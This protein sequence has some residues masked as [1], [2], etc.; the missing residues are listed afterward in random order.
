MNEPATLAITGASGFLGRSLLRVAA[1]H[2]FRVRALS[3]QHRTDLPGVE[4]FQGDISDDLVLKDLA[5]GCSSLIHAAATMQGA[6][7][8]VCRSIVDGTA[9]AAH[10]ASEAG[11]R[12]VHISSLA[13]VNPELAADPVELGDDIQLDPRPANRGGYTRGKIKAEQLVVSLRGKGLEAAIVRPAQLVGPGLNAVP[14]SVGI[15]VA[16]CRAALVG[17]S[18]PLPMVHVDDAATAVIMLTEL[19]KAPMSVNLVDPL[20]VSRRMLQ[21]SLRHHQIPGSTMPLIPLGPIAQPLARLSRRIL[22]GSLGRAAYRV[23]AMKS[24][25][26]WRCD[27]ALDIGWEPVHL[28]Q[29]LDEAGKGHHHAAH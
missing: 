12:L 5:A 29:W 17:M 6:D 14:P 27:R 25:A 15:P 21:R 26:T 10:A 20:R 23:T 8:M 7:D 28:Q 13:V 3:R 1:R 18:L 19:G 11:I 2:G 16:G 24:R 4:W 22:P 9:S